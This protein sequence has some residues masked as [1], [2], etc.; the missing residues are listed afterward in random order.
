M[1]QVRRLTEDDGIG[2][3]D[4]PTGQRLR[5]RVRREVVA[6][7]ADLLDATRGDHGA[8]MVAFNTSVTYPVGSV[9]AMV[10]SILLGGGGGGG[11]IDPGVLVAALTGLLGPDQL[12]ATL[13]GRID[14][15]DRV[16]GL[17]D[18]VAGL[19]STFGSTAAAA[20]SA[21]N[22]ATSANNAVA[23]QTN[24]VAAS[25]AATVSAG[26]ALTS[27][28]DSASA[29]TQAQTAQGSA[30]TSAAQAAG[31]ATSASGSASTATT[32][33]TV[34]TQAASAAGGAATAA[35]TSA[36]SA[37][38]SATAAATSASSAE[39]RRV[40]AQTAAASASTS[41]TNAA[42]SA[43]T[44]AGSAAVASTQAGLAA[45]AAG[46]ADGSA[47]AAATAAAS[48][49]VSAS[50]SA[51]SA[52]TATTQAGIAATSS[53]A[54]GSSATAA[55]NSAS[56]AA[57]SAGVASTAAS[58]ANTSKLSADTAASSASVSSGS[59]A[60][61]ASS[62][63]GSAAA[64][65]A[66]YNATV[67]ATGSLTAQV[68]NL[69]TAVAGPDGLSAQN[70]FKVSA[71]RT[72]GKKVYAAIGLAATAA[73]DAGESQILLDASKLLFV[74]N[75]DLNADPANLMVL[76]LVDGV[77]TL[78][79]PAA[80][81]GDASIAAGKLSVPQLSAISAN[82]G[83]LTAGLIRNASDSYR[84]DV[85]AGRSVVKTGAF[86]KVTG[87]PFGSSSQF[88]EWYG[89]YSADLDTCTESNAVYYLKTNGAA[90]FG[91]TL[92][93]GLL[94]SSIQTTDTSATASVILGPYSTNGGPKSIVLSYAFSLYYRCASNTG[95]INGA[96]GS[97]TVILERSLNN[98]SWIQ[99]GALVANEVQRSVMVDGEPGIP[100]SVHYGLGGS[101]TVVDNSAATADIRLRAR[102]SVRTLPT[103][104]GSAIFGSVTT[105]TTS[106]VSTE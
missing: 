49:S 36:G 41:A 42:Q 9:G 17:T 10:Q 106:V 93:A 98:G 12:T 2:L 76:G 6:F 53:N 5:V 102:V 51:A 22:A 27:A 75:S 72:D 1:S 31:S 52:A 78:I 105:Q 83:T 68:V 66:S 4:D 30:S 95:A 23:A 80:R 58:A 48:S 64:A 77:A 50:N 97:A 90:Y 39:Q 94:K 26:Q 104:G 32:Q 65:A 11:V 103:F 37:T 54:A 99:I 100:D 45:A 47:T 96:A 56:S 13:R 46:D 101:V 73:G 15:I 44:A 70:V 43:T 61:S 14:N 88:I 89:P 8:G 79:V 40:D 21:A 60:T 67:A 34:A 91:G 38:S 59:A 7:L 84:L 33:A 92:S 20:V 29:L 86:M 69:Q 24:A 35:I 62:A 63:S 16:G 87:A 3:T 57:T 81:I 19:T 28:N 55:S 74:P 25:N 85:T 71:T 82:V 18:Q